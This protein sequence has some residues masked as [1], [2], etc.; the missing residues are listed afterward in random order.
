[1]TLS[2]LVIDDDRAHGDATAEIVRRLGHDVVTARSGEEGIELLRRGGTDLV[3]TDLVMRGRSGLDVL[4]AAAGGPEVIVV[5]GFGSGEAAPAALRAGAA[6]YLTK[7]LSV[8]KFRSLLERVARRVKARRAARREGAFL[9]MV[10]ESPPMRQ[11]FDLVKR[12]ADSRAT[13][14]VE[15]ES[16]TG[17][18]LVA[19]AVHALS[20]R[21]AGPFVPVNCAALAPGVLESELFG[22]ERG[23]FTG[24][25]AA[26]AGRFEAADGGTLFLDEVAE[27]DARLQAKL[28]RAV[29]ERE[30]TRVGGNDPRVVDVRLVAATNRPLRDRVAEGA[31]RADLFFRLNVV[32]IAV[33]ALRDRPGDIPLLVDA[34]LSELSAEHGVP[35]PK[36]DDGLLR[37]LAELPWPGNV[38]EL[39]NCLESMLLVG[40]PCLTPADLPADAPVVPPKPPLSMRPIADVERELI[41]NT[42]KD[43][44][45]NRTRAAKALGISARTLYRRIKELGLS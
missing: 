10:G 20:P 26:R 24:A 8:E 39:R 13:V 4:V 40:G 2:V 35:R 22:H 34:F 41:L 42:L 44:E 30:V 9:G 15:G 36:V 6:A 14:L 3:V 45:G 11:L 23:A 37:R 1:V 21:A 19:L 32:R 29:E 33:P 5:T 7:P 31:F 25:H 18:E 27:M 43:L 12:A 17:K 28:L 38:R 16:G